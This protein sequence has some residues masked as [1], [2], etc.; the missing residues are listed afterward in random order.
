MNTP[1]QQSS[2]DFDISTPVP[3]GYSSSP[4]TPTNSGIPFVIPDAPKKNMS[5]VPRRGIERQLPV[6]LT[7]HPILRRRG[8][9]PLR[10]IVF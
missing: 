4:R 9:P 10:K 7:S 1:T 6:G 5:A 8:L 3:S 2:F